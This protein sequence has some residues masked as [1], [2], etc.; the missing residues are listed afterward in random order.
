[1]NSV[2]P[3][4]AKAQT[5]L[6]CFGL[7]MS[8]WIVVVSL[9]WL[10]QPASDQALAAYSI[11]ATNFFKELLMQGPAGW[12][13]HYLQG[14]PTV[15]AWGSAGTH[16]LVALGVILFGPWIGPKVVGMIALAIAA[17]GMFFLLRWISGDGWTGF[18]AGLL[19]LSF[20][21]WWSRLFE[22]EQL[23]IV[24][25]LGVLPWLLLS[26]ARFFSFPDPARALLAALLFSL[27][28]LT[29]ARSWQPFLPIIAVFSL[30][31]FLSTPCFRR[32][33]WLLLAIPAVIFWLAVLPTIA[34]FRESSFLIGNLFA[35]VAGWQ[36]VFSIHSAVQWID[37]GGWVSSTMPD[38]FSPGSGWNGSFFGLVGI[39]VTAWGLLRHGQ[40]IHS[41]PHWTGL[42]SFI[43]LS[44]FSFWLSTGPSGVFGGHMIF[45]SQ[46]GAA[47]HGSIA[48]SWLLLAA[49]GWVIYRLLPP[50][51]PGRWLLGSF[52][53][54]VYFFVP[55]FRLLSFIPGFHQWPTPSD[56]FQVGGSIFLLGAIAWFARMFIGH[57][58]KVLPRALRIA[59]IV[60]LLAI[61]W[62]LL[63]TR[64]FTPSHQTGSW[65]RLQEAVQVLGRVDSQGWVY[66]A[67]MGQLNLW[68][69]QWS[70]FPLITESFRAELQPKS[71]AVLHAA[72][73]LSLDSL[74]S[75]LSATGVTAVLLTKKETQEDDETIATLQSLF[76][77]LYEDDE[78][79]ILLNPK[80]LGLGF[81]AQDYLATK[82]S[83]PSMAVKA[84]AA[85]A[86]NLLLIKD[87]PEEAPARLRG[88]RGISSEED[89][90]T[91]AFFEYEDI[92]IEAFLKQN[93][94]WDPSGVLRF[95]NLEKDGWLVAT[96]SWHPDWTAVRNGESIQVYRALDAFPAVE[97]GT[98]DLVEFRYEPP[99]WY[100]LA[101][102]AS[103]PG[104]LLVPCLWVF[105]WMRRKKTPGQHDFRTVNNKSSIA[106]PLVIIPTYQEADSI[107]DVVTRAL[108]ASPEME[109]LVV[110]DDSPDGTASV[111][112][113]LPAFGQRLHLLERAG[114]R[115]L[116]TAY[117]DGFTWGLVGPY[118]VLIEMD[119][120]LSHDPMDLPRLLSTLEA[121]CDAAI[122]SRYLDGLRVKNWPEHRLWLSYWASVYVRLLTGMPL[123]DTTSGFKAL[124]REAV[125]NVLQGDFRAEGYGFQIELHYQLWKEG[126]AIQE[127]PILFTERRSGS[128]KM[129]LGIA[130]EAAWRVWELAFPFFSRQ[131]PQKREQ[132]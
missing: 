20:P 81:I 109:I 37:A 111:V 14:M 114:K 60:V 69:P 13:F 67:G 131:A 32:P 100:S 38:G 55:G 90:D 64:S 9:L 24:I 104:W 102:F 94:T 21:P 49:Q 118:D 115:G 119:A 86:E 105:F 65:A 41:S 5:P 18:W 36:Y 132:P 83:G 10:P 88:T 72:A 50:T 68:I 54:L 2:K 98:G 43:W 108:A 29:G 125:E 97:A 99:S 95:S 19:S 112:K 53:C 124:R 130:V 39:F 28:I 23:G 92:P 107:A 11:T 73:G 110:D 123:T 122:G 47:P 35:P 7:A 87:P 58:A 1:M 46:A 117:R 62:A 76:P 63:G 33:S 22:S 26:L 78:Y 57:S 31:H 91:P 44:L 121:G 77:A 116:G 103:L 15:T 127:V 59:A 79:L 85:A 42:R 80:N 113:K 126:W 82:D 84:L 12:D 120:D 66:P 8:V 51:L 34:F 40:E 27:L 16:G 101:V 96:T 56:F 70:G 4:I 128:T 6:L 93:A 30:I 52:V 106:K 61:D 129:T 17:T 75:Y 3:T 74:Q 48:L 89:K 25:A 45:L 71:T